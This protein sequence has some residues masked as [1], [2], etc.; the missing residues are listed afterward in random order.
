MDRMRCASRNDSQFSRPIEQL[1]RGC[2]ANSTDPAKIIVPSDSFK[3]TH[4]AN[5]CSNAAG[6]D[7]A[8]D[9]ITSGNSTYSIGASTSKITRARN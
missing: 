1:K 9:S 8:D 2:R 3:D 5:L 7:G 4:V 6:G